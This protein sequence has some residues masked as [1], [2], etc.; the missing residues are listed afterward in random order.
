MTASYPGQVSTQTGDAQSSFSICVW[1]SSTLQPGF[2]REDD[3]AQTARKQHTG[4]CLCTFRNSWLQ[5]LPVLPHLFWL[6]AASSDA[7]SS[8]LLRKKSLSMKITSSSHW[9]WSCLCIQES[10]NST[11]HRLC[12]TLVTF[13]FPLIQEK[14]SGVSEPALQI[15]SRKI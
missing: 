2:L 13:S 1:N 14:T 11:P 8:V 4:K 7:I 9:F 12:H 10:Q 5:P 3:C 15:S 6:S